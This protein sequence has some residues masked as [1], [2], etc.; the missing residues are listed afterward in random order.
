MTQTV[1]EAILRRERAVVLGALALLIALSWAWLLA[2]SGTGMSMAAMTT[3]AFPPPAM[4][5][6][7][8][9]WTFGYA[10]IMLAMWWVMMIAMMAPSAAP[11]V[12]LY[13][14]AYRH[15][16]K[17]GRLTGG[18]APV[19]VFVAG[20]LL[21]WLGF[22]IAAVAV[23]FALEQAGL[24]HSMLM[25][26]T[27]RTLTAALLVVAGAY[28]FLPLKQACLVQCRSPAAVI[29]GNF[30]PGRLGALRLGL[31]HG[32]Y[33][34]SC[35]WALMALLIAAGVMVVFWGHILG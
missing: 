8:M 33:C 31:R 21:A 30:Q 7:P 32:A 16:Q 23:Q 18:H 19:L 26:S 25:W 29:A 5:H 14:Q 9:P 27:N 12:L 17:L 6:M 4:P 15:Q 34:V 20:Y 1:A 35:C 28:Q 2:G 22:S 3:F 24:L 10:M 11:V 13:G